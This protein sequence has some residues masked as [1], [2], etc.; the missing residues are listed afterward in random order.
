L[1][2]W[3]SG[4]KRFRLTLALGFVEMIRDKRRFLLA[5]AEIDE[6]R[7]VYVIP[8]LTALLAAQVERV[9]ELE[10]LLSHII[11]HLFSSLKE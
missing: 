4:G 3:A 1:P 8:G 11:P 6:A 10:H 2:R 9:R 7:I 5:N